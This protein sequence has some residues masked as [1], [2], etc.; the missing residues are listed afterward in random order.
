MT[1]NVGFLEVDGVRI[2]DGC[3][4]KHYLTAAGPDR[5]H[6]SWNAPND[7]P[8][9]CCDEDAGVYAT[10]STVSNPA[11]WW[12]P[13]Q[14][15]SAD[16]FGVNIR[17]I[18]RSGGYN[19]KTEEGNPLP[20]IREDTKQYLF[21]DA[22]IVSSSCEGTRFGE[23]WLNRLFANSCTATGGAE[24]TFRQHCDYVRPA[25]QTLDDELHFYSAGGATIYA[26]FVRDYDGTITD[27]NLGA[28]LGLTVL[29]GSSEGDGSAWAIDGSQNLLFINPELAVATVTLPIAGLHTGNVTGLAWWGGVLYGITSTFELLRLNCTTGVTTVLAGP[30]T[31]VAADPWLG[32]NADG[33]YVPSA[34][35]STIATIDSSGETLAATDVFSASGTVTYGQSA[36]DGRFYALI[37]GTGFAELINLAGG[38]LGGELVLDAAPNE[39]LFAPWWRSDQLVT[40]PSETVYG[41]RVM[42]G[43]QLTQPIRIVPDEMFPDCCA[44]GRI[45]IVLE[46]RLPRLHLPSRELWA[47]DLQSPTFTG[48]LPKL[49]PAPIPA[50]VEEVSAQLNRVDRNVKLFRDGTWCDVNPS[51]STADNPCYRLVVTE[52]E[53]YTSPADTD[54]YGIVVYYDGLSRSPG[55]WS[56]EPVNA[57]LELSCDKTVTISQVLV[58]NPTYT[59]EDSSCSDSERACA[60]LWGFGVD[61]DGFL[62]NLPPLLTNSEI[63]DENAYWL[64]SGWTQAAIDYGF[65]RYFN[66]LVCVG[67][68]TDRD[69]TITDTFLSTMKSDCAA[70]GGVAG[71]IKMKVDG[72]G[73]V[74][75]IASG[76]SGCTGTFCDPEADCQQYVIDA[77]GMNVAA[78][79]SGDNVFGGLCES[80]GTINS[81]GPNAIPAASALDLS[82]QPDICQQW[83]DVST[84]TSGTPFV[85]ELTND[86]TPSDLGSFAVN[87]TWNVKSPTDLAFERT[88]GRFVA[89]GVSICTINPELCNEIGNITLTEGPDTWTANSWGHDTFATFPPEGFIGF[90]D[91]AQTT[92]DCDAIVS[93]TRIEGEPNCQICTGRLC[94]GGHPIEPYRERRSC[95]GAPLTG[96]GWAQT[97]TLEGG[98]LDLYDLEWSIE[99]GSTSLDGTSIEVYPFVEPYGPGRLDSIW[100]YRQYSN[101]CEVIELWG[102]E[103]DETISLNGAAEVFE[104]SCG[105]GTRDARLNARS[106]RGRVYRAKTLTGGKYI[107]VVVA[108]SD[109]FGGSTGSRVELLAH[110]RTGL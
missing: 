73:A 100:W 45:E 97:F 3:R 61:D 77:P 8:D 27:T 39:T 6:P 93:L 13:Y 92:A 96:N 54:E 95:W 49:D 24:V 108:P 78:S 11:P 64:S 18:T 51:F 71:L 101:P 15:A 38:G 23:E 22:E 81:A 69:I 28:D 62:T 83:V 36:P 57:A 63:C 52:W 14:P 34:T 20:A 86:S 1:Y 58:K 9:H 65:D 76:N 43:V 70:N 66:Y 12:D 91:S 104:V 55:I 41:K 42:S 10:P 56:W 102:A 105:I 90:E 19:T 107:A 33:F 47:V 30:F 106:E 82:S 48:V 7:C 21:I 37:T 89:N 85:V 2:V 50:A 99:T 25:T 16:F 75:F 32:V 84:G 5:P 87:P 44:G 79:Q 80:S 98:D 26:N 35:A 74:L 60:E 72:T 88:N 110:Q 59:P 109:A 40:V 46:S 68:Q 29:T 53:D 4:L 103:P 17:S 94:S 31:G 67:A